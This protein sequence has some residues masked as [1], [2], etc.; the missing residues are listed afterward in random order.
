M[1]RSKIFWLVKFQIEISIATTDFVV[2]PRAM[3]VVLRSDK[4]GHL[5]SESYVAVL[6][7]RRVSMIDQIL[8]ELLVFLVQLCFVLSKA[9]SSSINN[10]E[11]VSHVLHVFDKTL[12]VTVQI[13]LFLVIIFHDCKP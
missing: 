11:I 2:A 9:D 12:A 10:G 13:D 1:L 6:E 4:Q 3:P 8:D 7:R 5:T